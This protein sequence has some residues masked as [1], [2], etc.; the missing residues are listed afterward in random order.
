MSQI[1]EDMRIKDAL[2]EFF[3]A[4]FEE[5][6]EDTP[7]M[8]KQIDLSHD[9][10]CIL[11]E[12]ILALP[13]DARELFYGQYC[14]GMSAET[15]QT[16]FS[17]PS[18]IGKLQYYKSIL[19]SAHKLTKEETISEQSFR[20][21]SEMALDEDVEQT[22]KECAGQGIIPFSNRTIHLFRGIGKGAAAAAVIFAVGFASA[23]TV[24]A[25]FREK[26]V[27]WFIETFKEFSVFNSSSNEE[28]TIED[29]KSYHPTFIPERY[30]HI[31]TSETPVS[32]SFSYAAEDGEALY[33]TFTLPGIDFLTDTENM[34]IQKLEY[35]GGEAYMMFD[36]DSRGTLAFSLDGIPVYISGQI[37]EDEAY[38]IADGIVKMK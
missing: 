4:R 9:D 38:A 35:M 30:Q 12:Q 31:G 16:M 7:K 1:T 20:E 3:L 5:A 36:E 8:Y 25:E 13:E 10:A 14:F 28:L 18:P 22:E 33:V 11:T 6:E 21:A 26:V 23:V 29:L 2:E 24:N 32:I 15:L 17:V 19:S 37:S 34:D 27:R